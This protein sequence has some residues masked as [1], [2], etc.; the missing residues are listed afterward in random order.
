MEQRT[1]HEKTHTHDGFLYEILSHSVHQLSPR[2]LW[3]NGYGVGL[4]IRRLRVRVSSG[5]N[6]ALNEF[7]F[8]TFRL[9]YE[10]GLRTEIVFRQCPARPQHHQ[11]KLFEVIVNIA[12]RRGS[13]TDARV[14][15]TSHHATFCVLYICLY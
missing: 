7:N 10:K 6:F 1:D 5:S 3:P 11:N 4:R 14:H 12:T 13:P 8:A 15:F 2:A 9:I